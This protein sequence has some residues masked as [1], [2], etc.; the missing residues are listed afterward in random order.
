MEGRGAGVVVVRDGGEGQG[1]GGGGGGLSGRGY[2][3]GRSVGELLTKRER[4]LQSVIIRL[5]NEE[6]T[7][8]TVLTHFIEPCMWSRLVGLNLF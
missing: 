5:T 2:H 4:P 6:S 1:E 3:Y 7:D 8:E